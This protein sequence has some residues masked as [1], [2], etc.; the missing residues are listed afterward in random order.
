M[1]KLLIIAAPLAL[2]IPALH[3]AEPARGGGDRFAMM[4][5]NGD[6]KID[7]AELT[8]VAEVE[9]A[10]KGTPVDGAKIDEMIRTIDANGDGAVD[11]GEM[12]AMRK[13]HGAGAETAKDKQ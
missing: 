8:K 6:G 7:K 12:N 5:A 13:A 11:R 1:K 2:A 3:A 10:K 4:D 9:A